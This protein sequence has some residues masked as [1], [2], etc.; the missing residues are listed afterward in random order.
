MK[1]SGRPPHRHSLDWSRDGRWLMTAGENE[2]DRPEI[3]YR[4]SLATGEITPFTSLPYGWAD[5]QPSFSPDGRSVV[6]VR[7][8]GQYSG[9]EIFVQKLD[10]GDAIR[11][12][13]VDDWI[14][15]LAWLTGGRELVFLRGAGTMWRVPASGGELTR[16]PV[17][18]RVRDFAVSPKGDRLLYSTGPNDC[19]IWSATGPAATESIRP[20]PLITSTRDDQRPAFSPDG[21]RIAFVSDRDGRYDIWICN[22]DGRDCDRTTRRIE[23]NFSQPGFPVVW[24]PDGNQIAYPDARADI[25]LLEVPSRFVHPV[26][27]AN[28][29][30]GEVPSAWSA[31]GRWLYF[32]SSRRRG[33][34]LRVWR[35]QLDSGQPVPVTT[36][37]G[38][39]AEESSDG[40]TVYYAVWPDL[41]RAVPAGVWAVPAAGGDEALVL[42]LEID[43]HPKN[44]TIWRNQLVY[45]RHH[46]QTRHSIE[47]F[48]LET[49]RT[50]RIV[51]LETTGEL[52][53]GFDVSPDG[54]RVL[55][56]VR[57]RSG[58]DLMLV[59]AFR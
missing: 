6:F 33:E 4:V 40:R 8:R 20:A 29:A 18:D 58:S 31:D 38:G 24:S 52:C 34:H 46:S 7:A 45:P 50:S 21:R 57:A 36:G 19:D 23:E 53:A 49:R 13:R 51:D 17:S 56:A 41:A 27:H 39:W 47:R 11:V 54:R 16:L 1:S 25:F 26:A 22:D 32:H 9:N 37:P 55:Y 59:D 3:L 30:R 15:D 35:V 44:W 12:A 10:G 28:S 2:P 43:G 48:D 42:P 14:A 5:T